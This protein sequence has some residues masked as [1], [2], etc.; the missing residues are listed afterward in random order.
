MYVYM[1]IYIYIYMISFYENGRESI[2]LIMNLSNFDKVIEHIELYVD[3][4]FTVCIIFFAYT[5]VIIFST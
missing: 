5:L 4:K 1:L 3:N 2:D